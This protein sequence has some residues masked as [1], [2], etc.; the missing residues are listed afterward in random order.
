[1]FSSS[2][3]D[4]KHLHL[5][6][7]DKS[8]YI[9]SILTASHPPQPLTS[10][11]RPSI[12]SL[13]SARINQGSTECDTIRTLILQ[14]SLD[15]SKC[16]S[17]DIPSMPSMEIHSAQPSEYRVPC[18]FA[19]CSS[20]RTFQTRCLSPWLGWIGSSVGSSL[21]GCCGARSTACPRSCVLVRLGGQ[22]WVWRWRQAGS[23]RI[24][25]AWFLW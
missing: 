23:G 22:S 13:L 9:A 12:H 2:N 19:F 18:S 10:G 1:M 21:G 6:N 14:Q 7:T 24:E 20:R 25:A 5:V 17:C 8:K 3:F 4:N 11:S 16:L 15:N